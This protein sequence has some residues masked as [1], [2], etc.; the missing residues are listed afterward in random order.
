MS[1]YAQRETIEKLTRE[2]E[3]LKR[4]VR[5]L[6]HIEAAAGMPCGE[7]NIAGANPSD[8]ELDATFGVPANISKGMLKLLDAGGAETDVFLAVPTDTSWWYIAL[9]KAA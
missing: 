2:V 6:E 3:A 1:E 7:D 9:T 5:R 8:S 4:T